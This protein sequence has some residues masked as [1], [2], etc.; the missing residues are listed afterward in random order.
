MKEIKAIEG[1]MLT[2]A[3]EYCQNFGHFCEAKAK[4]IAAQTMDEVRKLL[5]FA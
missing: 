5:K 3:G 4:E 2:S 1:I